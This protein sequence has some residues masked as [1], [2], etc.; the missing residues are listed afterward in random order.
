MVMII[1][2]LT[3]GLVLW[4]IKWNVPKLIMN[5]WGV[6]P[7]SRFKGVWGRNGKW[8]SA[9]SVDGLRNQSPTFYSETDA[10]IWYNYH[11][12]HYH[13]E[14]AWLNDLTSIVYTHD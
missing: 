9:I 8:R 12:A 11:A 10:A 3:F 13:R 7:T 4:R 2:R 5:N 14:F 1:A 6:E